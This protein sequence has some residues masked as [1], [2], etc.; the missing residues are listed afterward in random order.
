MKKQLLS[1][2]FLVLVVCFIL[3]SIYSNRFQLSDQQN[4]VTPN[5]YQNELEPTVAYKRALFWRQLEVDSVQCVLCP[6]NCRISSGDRGLCRVRENI[7][8]S[9]YTLNFSKPVAMSVSPIEKAPFHHFF[10][11][12]NRKTIATAGCNLVCMHC[13]NWPISQGSVEDLHYLPMSPE[14]VI[15]DVLND[16]LTSVSFTYSEPTVFFEYMYEIS[17][18]AR[19]NN[20]KTN[21]VTNGF[22][23]PEPLK[24]LLVYMDSVRVDLKAF[25]DD[26]YGE[27]SGGRLEPVLNSLKIIQESGTHLE[28]INLIIPT[29][30]DDPESISEM[31]DWIVDNLGKDVPVHFNRFF[32]QFKLKNLPPTPVETLELAAQIARD[33]GIRFVYIGNVP[34]HPYNNTFCPQCD[35]LV[36]K[37]SALTV[38]SNNL[39]NGKCSNCD[40]LLPGEW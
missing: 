25:S 12:H 18:L 37:R 7:N 36:I 11:G 26:F 33:S 9:L 5:D 34:G 24:Q 27:I 31:S 20:I 13:Q 15:S 28:I 21:L 29:L 1:P 19:E 3:I 23:N 30:N 35:E 14:S 8:G 40:Y 32:P 6:H 2:L 4:A 10:P 22:I 38:I 16:G 39:I 17:K